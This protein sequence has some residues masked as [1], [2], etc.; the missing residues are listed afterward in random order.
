[1]AIEFAA[2]EIPSVREVELPV[3]YK[4]RLLTCSYRADFVCYESIIVELKALQA[5]TGIEQ[6]QLLNYLKATRLERG[7]LLNFGRQ[8]LEFKRV[9]FSNLRKSAQSAD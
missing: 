4:G 5:I 8:S 6:A 7:L 1:M 3:H 9:V 2:R